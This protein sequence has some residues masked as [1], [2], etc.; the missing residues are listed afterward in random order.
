LQ[1]TRQSVDFVR[2]GDHYDGAYL[3]RGHAALLHAEKLLQGYS[4]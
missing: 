2:D 3:L 4:D 1:R